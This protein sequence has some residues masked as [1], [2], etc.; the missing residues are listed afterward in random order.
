MLTSDPKAP[1][2]ERLGPYGT[3]Y[4]P[5]CYTKLKLGKD[6]LFCPNFG[7]PPCGWT[8]RK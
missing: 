5:L 2:D 8:E 7:P 6:G 4:C 1:R 3:R